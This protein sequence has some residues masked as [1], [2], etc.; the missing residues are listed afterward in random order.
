MGHLPVGA[1]PGR[2]GPGGVRVRAVQVGVFPQ[3]YTFGVHGLR[4]FHTTSK[5]KAGEGTNAKFWPPPSTMTWS[6][7]VNETDWRKLESL[8]SARL[9]DE[10]LAPAFFEIGTSSKA[11]FPTGP[12]INLS[13]PG[14][15]IVVH[16]RHGIE[17][18][19]ETPPDTHSA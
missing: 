3:V 16:L 7:L 19:Y 13:H 12:L 15:S 2:V 1:C 18:P 6:N 14:T 10:P 8:S 9:S 5:M 4:G 11:T 17:R